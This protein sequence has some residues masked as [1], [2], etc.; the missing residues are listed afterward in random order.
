MSRESQTIEWKES[1]R[2]DYL[3]WVCG[4]ANSEGGVL[5]IG[6]ND[7]GEAVGIGNGA[8]LME[9]LPYKIRDLLGIIVEVNRHVEGDAELLEIH[10]PA[11]NNPISYRGRYYLRSGSTLQELKGAALDRFL[12]QRQGRTWDSVPLPGLKVSDLSVT[13]LRKFRELATTSGRLSSTDLSS[14]DAGLLEK[15]KLTEGAYL[16]RS[17]ALLF[18]KEPDRFITGAFVKIGFFVTESELAYHDE[19]RGTLFQQAHAVVDLL[20]TKYMK[21]AISYQGLQR[22]ER[23]PVPY[24]A[25]REAVL[26]ALVHRDYA[27]HAPIQI[28]VYENKLKIWNPAVLPEDWSLETLLGEHASH[29]Y[30]P[31]VANAFFR[32]GEIESWGRGIERIYS[33]CRNADSPPPNI[34][35]DGHDLWVKFPFADNYLTA[36]RGEIS[37]KGSTTQETTQKTTQEKI[38]LLLKEKPSI[39]RRELA[40]ELPLSEGGIKYHLRKLKEQSRIRHV[41]STKKGHWEVL[42]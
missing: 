34:Q 1:W 7:Q 8:K 20:R 29:P 18:H 36:V 28:R 23:F 17:A 27:V 12:L 4:F 10:V 32:A 22:I 11:Y 2:D 25:L 5:V 24:E 42:Q 21:A 41:G 30:N 13:S 9:D 31:D 19:I 16:K 40:Q 26:N 6:R 35:L 3:R 39:T 33:A 37:S 14:S 38:I 15:L